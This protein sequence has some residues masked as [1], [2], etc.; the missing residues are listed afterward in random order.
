L[1]VATAVCKRCSTT[2]GSRITGGIR[3]GGGWWPLAQAPQSKM[4]A[5]AIVVVKN[6]SEL[7][8]VCFNAL[9]G[10]P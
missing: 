2:A 3:F 8:M 10:I 7:F 6:V 5:M 9:S 1:P 4:I